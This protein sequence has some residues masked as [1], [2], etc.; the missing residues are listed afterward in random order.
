MI[1]RKPSSSLS[2]E[3]IT[4][5][6]T[7]SL[8]SDQDYPQC[9]KPSISHVYLH[10]PSV[11]GDTLPSFV[12]VQPLGGQDLQAEQIQL[13]VP[14]ALFAGGGTDDGGEDDAADSPNTGDL[15]LED[16]EREE[17]E[18]NDAYTDIGLSLDD[19][20]AN[21]QARDPRIESWIDV[22]V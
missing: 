18:K 21:E 6:I 8:S 13:P 14:N 22:P 15:F 1:H 10:S 20:A 2:S 9:P 4:Q 7:H 12:N 19:A 11:E 16:D 17:I 5:A 3:P